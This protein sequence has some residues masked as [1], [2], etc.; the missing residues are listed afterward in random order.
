MH[1][2]FLRRKVYKYILYYNRPEAQAVMGNCICIA[3]GSAQVIN[4]NAFL[5]LV[6][7][8]K[9]IM[10]YIRQSRLRF[11]LPLDLYL[12]THMTIGTALVMFAI[13]HVF[14]HI[15]DFVL[16]TDTEN[17]SNKEL[18]AIFGKSISFPS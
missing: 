16:V 3:R 10:T 18:E 15:C 5:I 8:C 7:M 2:I 13:A 14:A 11:I 12:E 6:P 9:H 17:A 4:V 1:L